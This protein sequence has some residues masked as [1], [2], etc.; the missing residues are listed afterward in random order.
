MTRKTKNRSE[1]PGY[2]QNWLGSESA[3]YYMADSIR[4]YWLERG[5]PAIK[6]WVE[7][8]QRNLPNGQIKFDYSIRS[9]MVCGVPPREAT[10]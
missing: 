4:H 8:K 10:A 3:A 2:T 9:N 7:E 5:Y 6:V 1:G